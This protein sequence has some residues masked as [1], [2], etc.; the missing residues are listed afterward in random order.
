MASSKQEIGSLSIYKDFK[1][2]KLS[3]YAPG[4]LKLAYEKDGTPKFQLLEMRYTGTTAYGDRGDKRFMN[5]VQFTVEMEEVSP[6]DLKAAKQSVGSTP[7]EL[8]PLPIRDIEAILVTPVGDPDAK[9]AYKKVGKDGSLQ[10]EGTTGNSD[11]NGYWTERTFTLKLENHEAQLLWEQVANG[12]LA[13]S[14]SYAFYADIIPFTKGDMRVT[15][16]SSAEVF[17]SENADK[18]IT[19]TVAVTQIVKADAFPVRIDTHQ[20]PDLMKKIDINEGIPPAYAAFEV[21]CFDF[22]EDLRPDLAIKAIDISATGVGGQTVSIPTVKFLRSE[23]DLFAQ[24]IHFPYAVRM[25]EPFRYRVV[26]YTKEGT[27]NMGEWRTVNDWTSQLD[28]TT[29]VKENLFTKKEVDIEVP[30]N[31]FAARGVKQVS[32]LLKYKFSNKNYSTIITCKPEDALPVRQATI[33]CDKSDP[34]S[35]EVVWSF[36]DDTRKSSPGGQVADDNYLYISIPD[37]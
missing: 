1:D 34:I 22:T 5:V 16:G 14:L 3:Y 28:I 6:A 2:P 26:E 35:Y 4:S 7:V 27:R 21:R 32:I 37:K 25:T 11:R 13:L 23:P 10:S 8:R 19:D 15:G 20:W 30:L 33:K 17:E 31:E 29:L 24:Q 18:L 12:Q 9:S 36:A